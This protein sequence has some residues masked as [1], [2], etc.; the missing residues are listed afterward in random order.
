MTY[1]AN[2]GGYKRELLHQV[3]TLADLPD[4]VTCTEPE[5]AATQYASR[6]ALAPLT[7]WP[8]TTSGAARSTSASWRRPRAGSRSSDLPTGSSTSAASTSTRRSSS[9]SSRWSPTSCRARTR[10]TRSPRL[11]GAPAPG[12][13]GRQGGTVERP[14]GDHLGVESGADD[15]AEADPPGARGPH[16]LTAARHAGRDERALRSAHLTAADLTTIVLVGGS[17]RIPLVS[18]L[19][20]SEFG[21]RT[22][23]DTHPKHDIALGAVRYHPPPPSTGPPRRGHGRAVAH[24]QGQTPPD[25]TRAR[26]HPGDWTRRSGEAGNQEAVRTTRV[27]ASPCRPG[28]RLA[29]PTARECGRCLGPQGEGGSHRR[30]RGRRAGGSGDGCRGCPKSNRDTDRQREPAGDLQYR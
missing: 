20:Q 19:L 8:F 30:C 11:A 5:A 23:L 3:V 4:A 24:P 17:S 15:V 21:V 25:H 16:L 9:T 28:D 12:V 13:R 26:A 7:R 2:W 22:A 29:G 14:R 1:P 6:A 10:T 18:H 27:G